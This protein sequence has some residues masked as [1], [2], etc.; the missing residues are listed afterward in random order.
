MRWREHILV[1]PLLT[2]VAWI[3]WIPYYISGVS[4]VAIIDWLRDRREGRR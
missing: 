4:E 3:L 1:S 2:I